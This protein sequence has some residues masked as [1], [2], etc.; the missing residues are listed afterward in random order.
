MCVEGVYSVR[1]VNVERGN[2]ERGEMCERVF[3]PAKLTLSLRVT[4][5]RDDGYHLIDAEMVSLD[6]GDQ[7]DFTANGIGVQMKAS[8]RLRSAYGARCVSDI[9]EISERDNLVSKALTLT[10][11]QAHVVVHKDIPLA[12][13]LGGG[14]S[15]AAAVLRWA[16]C[17]DA[18][19]A[20]D[21]GADVPFCLI[22]GRAHVSGV[23]E[24]VRPLPYQLQTYTLLTPPVQSSTAAVYKAWDAL[25]GPV[26]GNSNDLELAALHVTPELAFWRDELG[27]ATGVTPKL[28]GSGSTWFVNGTHPIPEQYTHIARHTSTIPGTTPTT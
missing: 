12:A 5:V 23:G 25:G 8:A 10:G 18:L 11:K 3:S 17:T 2:V 27:N 15:N 20:L 19:L 4:G 26:G 16:G 9:S 13:G 1:A 21:I 14:S 6:F 7:L 22:G 24:V 28:A